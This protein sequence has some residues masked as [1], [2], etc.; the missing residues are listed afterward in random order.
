VIPPRITTE[1]TDSTH[2]LIR[3]AGTWSLQGPS[4]VSDALAPALS[5]LP[6]ASTLVFDVSAVDA[7]DNLLPAYLTRIAQIARQRE[8]N[9]D[10]TRLP[11][12]LND[13]LQLALTVP[14]RQGIGGA[15]Q[16]QN[17]LALLGQQTWTLAADL[18]GF[19]T[20]IGEV[21][22]AGLALLMGG[23]RF[24]WVDLWLNIQAAGPGA[25]PIVTLL[26]LLVGLI[27]AFVGALQLSLFG[28]QVYIANLVGLGM[29]REMGALMTAVIMAGRTG[30][31]FAAQLGAMQVNNEIDAL[32][33]LGFSPV[34]FL[35]LPRLL[36]LILMMPLLCLYANIMGMLGGAIVGITVFD[37][38]LLQY[39]NRTRTAVNLESFAIGLVKCTV[40]GILIAL[41]GCLRGIQC[42]R[43]ASA[44]GD[45]ATSAMVTS[46]VMIVVADSLITLMCNRLGI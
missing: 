25:L 18:G 16:R 3:F 42:G 19:I 4:P 45:A 20:F 37:M 1:Q 2:L 9:V 6:S 10:T 14:P 40:F 12:A 34:E 23:A 5:R 22:L 41:A 11:P 24:R 7:W 26:S 15:Q 44:V 21:V 13:L 8:W 27:L 39:I 43:S 38:S 17:W 28:A 30:S 29:T 33:T 32:K 35:V 36:A 31:A 46:I